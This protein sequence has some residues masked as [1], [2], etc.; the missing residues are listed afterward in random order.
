MSNWD[1]AKTAFQVN[2]SWVCFYVCRL[3]GLVKQH[4][5][6]EYDSHALRQFRRLIS[7][8]VTI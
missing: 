7:Q 4:L 3:A 8:T 6:M 1:Q 5:L 2:V